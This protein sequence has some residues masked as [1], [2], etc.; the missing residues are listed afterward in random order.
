L[1]EA[2]DIEQV[3]PIINSLMT[4]KTWLSDG[5]RYVFVS[6]SLSSLGKEASNLFTVQQIQ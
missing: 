2:P 3:F 6:V 5:D 1:D 4:R